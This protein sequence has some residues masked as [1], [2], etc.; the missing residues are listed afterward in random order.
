MTFRLNDRQAPLCLTIP[1]NGTFFSEDFSFLFFYQSHSRFSASE[2]QNR[3]ITYP[4]PW[5]TAAANYHTIFSLVSFLNTDYTFRQKKK[6]KKRICK[7]ESKG[8]KRNG[9]SD[10]VNQRDREGE[11]E[12]ERERGE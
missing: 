7:T 11:R 10:F 8:K 3:Q 4:F 1:I 6:K 9:A 5:R 2:K 12:R